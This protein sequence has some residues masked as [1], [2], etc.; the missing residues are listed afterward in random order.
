MN[1]VRVS[2]SLAGGSTLNEMEKRRKSRLEKLS[3]PLSGE[4][5]AFGREKT[6]QLS[7]SP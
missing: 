4:M 6:E 2:T 1:N 5:G 3:F 7:I